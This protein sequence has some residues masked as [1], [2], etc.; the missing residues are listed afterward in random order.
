MR[1]D[2]IL[3]TETWLPRPLE[4]VFD[5]FKKAENLQQLT[6]PWLDFQILTPLPV[7]LKQGALIDYRLKLYGVPL[8]WKT[9]ISLWEP[10]YRFVDAQLQGPYRKWVH[11]H[12]FE[13]VNGGTRMRDRVE[14][15]LPGGVLAP[16][17]H[18]LFVKRN[19]ETIFRFREARITRIFRHV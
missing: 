8:L 5:F 15:R 3:E 7:E 17:A 9:E 18:R 4:E 11:T 10:P 1:Q 6:P 2:Y 13:A 16:L 14:Y 12:T 19:V